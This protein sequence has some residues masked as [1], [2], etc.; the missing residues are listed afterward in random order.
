VQT[1]IKPKEK[2]SIL[3][4][5]DLKSITN[6]ISKMKK[7]RTKSVIY[8]DKTLDWDYERLGSG[9][10][11]IVYDLNKKYVLK[12]A[13]NIRGLKSNKTEYDIY[14]QSSSRLRKHLCPVIDYGEGWIIMERM[15]RLISLTEEI[16]KKLPRLRGK[17][18]K[19]GIVTRSLRSKNLSISNR[20]NRI[21]IIDYGSFR[22]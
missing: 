15:Q 6:W 16:E 1:M 12:V 18:K 21:V 2:K 19:E 10:T 4:D 8:V 11:R 14:Q 13:I 20:K 7:M 22:Y 3:S 9:K 17:F 5:Q